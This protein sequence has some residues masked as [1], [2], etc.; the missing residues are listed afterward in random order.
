MLKVGVIGAT[1]YTG[2]EII[3]ILARHEGVDITTLQAVIEKEEP[4]SDIFPSLKG[5][6]DIMC[7]K[8]DEAKALK[9]TDLVFLALP[10]TVSMQVAPGFIKAGKK[11]IDLSAD[12]RLDVMEYEKWYG[13]KHKDA[14]NIEKAVYGLPELYRKEIKASKLLANP[15]CFPTGASLALIPLV[16]NKFA[17]L[18]SIIIDSKTG[19]TGGGRKPSIALS[20]AEVNEN[21]KAY[22]VNEHQHMPE[23][24]MVLGRV[25]GENVKVTFV[26]H[27]M[28]ISRGIFTTAYLDLAKKISEAEAVDLYKNFYKGEPFVKVLNSGALPT[29][30]DVQHTNLC[31]IGVKAKGSKIIV[32]S[33]IDNLLKGA[34]GQAV[35][36]MNIMCGFDEKEG[37]A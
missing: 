8:P 26:P 6:V 4:I 28:S 35:Q 17:D 3:K 18:N 36:N 32:I 24:N 1:G 20:F 31:T 19:A 16:K 34:A 13:V 15:G 37:L 5:S 29:L 10:H 33:C 2:E 21:I 9:N 12:Y 30:R 7:T 14:E 22:K 23:I 11:V 25:S 27:L